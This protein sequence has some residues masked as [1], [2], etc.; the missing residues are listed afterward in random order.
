MYNENFLELRNIS[1]HFG[2]VQALKQVNFSLKTGEI[3]CLVGENGSGK[4]TLIKI[5][6][7][8]Y[9]PEPGGEITIAGKV[10]SHLTPSASIQQ[11]IQVIYQDLSLFPNLT[12]AENIGINQYLEPGRKFVDSVRIREIAHETMAK[13]GVSLIVIEKYQLHVRQGQN[14]KEDYE[15]SE[16]I[17]S[18]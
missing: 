4:S 17:N 1:K 2:G 7:G 11:G 15:F 5:I 13:I 18:R 14:R 6:S 16:T 8:V 9:A 3:H 12:V 10:Q